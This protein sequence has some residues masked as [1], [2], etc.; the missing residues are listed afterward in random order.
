MH[1]AYSRDV[2][3]SPAPSPDR[4]PSDQIRAGLANLD[5]ILRTTLALSSKPN[6]AGGAAA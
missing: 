3:K 2:F 4:T 6:G 1:I 5:L